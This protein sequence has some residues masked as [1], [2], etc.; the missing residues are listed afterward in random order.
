[1]DSRSVGCQW[2]K[3]GRWQWLRKNSMSNAV[4]MEMFHV[5][6]PVKILGVRL[7]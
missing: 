1:M 4:V 2:L 5:A 3:M 7:C 6:V